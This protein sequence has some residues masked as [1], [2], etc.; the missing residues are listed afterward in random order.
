[1]ELLPER[2][3]ERRALI[4]EASANYGVSYQIP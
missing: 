1:M 2:S 4:E 3:R